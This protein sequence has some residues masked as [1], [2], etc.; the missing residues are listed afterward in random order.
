[1]TMEGEAILIRFVEV[2]KH[3]LSGQHSTDP[4]LHKEKAFVLL[5]F[6]TTEAM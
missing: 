3:S 4:E 6:W 5:C 2:G 1:M